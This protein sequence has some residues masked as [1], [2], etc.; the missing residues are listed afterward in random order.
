MPKSSSMQESLSLAELIRA[1]HEEL[2]K[3][4]LERESD[5]LAPLFEV[6]TLELEVNFVVGETKS[7]EA[8]CDIKVVSVGGDMEWAKQQVHNVKLTLKATKPDSQLTFDVIEVGSA[9]GKDISGRFPIAP[10]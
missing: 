10:E 3:S 7:A 8:G 5:D 4:Q 9:G 1:V 2:I 6:D